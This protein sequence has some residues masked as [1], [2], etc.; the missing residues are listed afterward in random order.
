MTRVFQAWDQIET[1]CF[2]E[3]N[4]KDDDNNK[5]SKVNGLND[6]NNNKEDND[7]DDDNNKG[8]SDSKGISALGLDE[9]LE[10][11]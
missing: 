2:C 10:F 1:W 6:H 11:S 5:D 7:K 4:D 9:D 3:D 8:N